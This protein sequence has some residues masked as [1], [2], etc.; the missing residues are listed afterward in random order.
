MILKRQKEN[1]KKMKTITILWTGT[2]KGR[3]VWKQDLSFVSDTIKIRRHKTISLN[4]V[5]FL[6]KKLWRNF[7]FKEKHPQQITLLLQMLLLK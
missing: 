5:E 7:Q 2:H 1:S 3:I 4:A 6:K